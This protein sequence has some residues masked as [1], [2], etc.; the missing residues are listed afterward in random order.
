M[1][2]SR[3][4][5]ERLT[6]VAIAVCG[7][8]A[9]AIGGLTLIG[10]RLQVLRLAAW[11]SELI[12]MSPAAAV[13]S[14]ILGAAILLGVAP[15]S[16]RG[17]VGIRI[18]AAASVLASSFL[19]GL[20]LTGRFASVEHL[21][22]DIH[23]TV[24]NAPLGFIALGSALCFLVV[25]A[26][27][28][29]CSWP[30]EHRVVR[31]WMPLIGGS[32]VM[33]A[34]LGL[35]LINITD[36]AVLY[37][38]AHIPPALNTALSLLL[39]GLALMLIAL[40]AAL[41][42]PVDDARL[43]ASRL[44]LTALFCAFVV[45]I[46]IGG[47]A[48]YQQEVREVERQAQD[49]LQTISQLRLRELANWRE[50]RLW[51][52]AQAAHS[53][54]SLE[55]VRAFLDAA[56]RSDRQRSLTRFFDRYLT[57]VEYD[58]VLL[59]DER[60]R[61]ELSLPATAD[62]RWATG[63]VTRAAQRALAAGK[64]SLYDFY[65]DPT[66]SH[67]S[68]ALFVPV[69]EGPPGPGR[70]LGV[71]CLRI[72]PDLGLYAIVRDWPSSSRS[73]ES[74]LVRR[75]GDAALFLSNLKF[76]AHAAL[77]HRATTTES[78][79]LAF[80]AAQGERGFVRSVNYRGAT[81]L[82]VLAAVPSSPWFLV[83]QIDEAELRADLR[84][85]LVLILAFVVVLVVGAG[86]ALGGIWH[87]QRST[88]HEAQLGLTGALRN[89]EARLRLAVSAADEGL[90]DLDLSTGTAVVTDEY[91]TLFGW[92]PASLATIYERLPE[93]LHPNDMATVSAR[94]RDYL[95]GRIAD[96]RAEFR[97]ADHTGGWRWALSVGRIV[98]RS[99]EGAPLRMLG[100]IKDISERRQA[101]DQ[102]RRSEETLRATATQLRGLL[103]NSPTV[104]YTMRPI[105]GVLR[106]VEVSEN[107]E[108]LFGYSQEEAL[109][110]S[111]WADHIAPEDRVHV[112]S[113]V[114]LIAE[115]DEIAHEFRV[116]RKD[117][118]ISWIQDSLRCTA[119]EHGRPVEVVGA[120]TDITSRKMAELRSKRL[121]ALY[122]TLSECNQAIVRSTRA[123][124]LYAAVCRAAV[125]HGGIAL[126]WI[127]LVDAQGERVVPV[128]AFG[129]STT[130]LDGIEISVDPR[131]A[132][133]RGPT[134]TAVREDRAAWSE[135]F[136]HDPTTA[137][138]HERA[139]GP[140]WSF[141][142]SLPLRRDG[143]AMGALTIYTRDQTV[144][145]EEARALL[146]E[147]S[148]N[149]SYALD[150]FSHEARR[151]DADRALRH[152]VHEKDVL[153]K[154]VHHRVKNNLQLISS[155]LR[156]ETGRTDDLRVHDVLTE[157]QGRILSMALLHETLYRSADLAH[158][159]LG[160]YLTQLARQAFRSL[161]P[162]GHLQLRTTLVDAEVE[163]DQ[164]IPCGL[165]VNELV[166]NAIK[167]GFPDDAPG[168][169]TVSLARDG[170][171]LCLDVRDDGVGLPDDLD[172][173]RATSLGL[174]LV[175]VLA[176]QLNGTLT[177]DSVAGAHFSLRFVPRLSVSE[178]ARTP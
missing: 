155:L 121:T 84:S 95:D 113:A 115:R 32:A 165:L 33:G 162:A 117:G 28:L 73:A 136:P 132:H 88:F 11:R 169:I 86:S 61:V 131:S 25:G 15:P 140:G 101:E 142:G 98:E 164:A 94:L 100:A 40:R 47:W 122:A 43:T 178:P 63:E 17:Q 87:R 13:L 68:L 71:V 103:T 37:E 170:E 21:G 23:G 152:S 176:T 29:I 44:L 174:H 51:D 177:S 62:P 1:P 119:R 7:A 27:L 5:N 89:S 111:W 118:S 175:S 91:A 42:A 34:G 65:L 159:N 78:R 36:G 128:A 161:A 153:L 10:W 125:E 56:S 81:V 39:A 172:A 9:V 60:G 139:R 54:V 69:T 141:S 160:H 79:T 8:A 24:N 92:S 156:L 145:D 151:S 3:V 150:S 30:V 70:A 130:Y 158:I 173:R 16:H 110:P 55:V 41:D 138:W 171:A 102:L 90:W 146:V 75:D 66:E 4:R 127:G 167:H 157:M 120:W 168:T 19:L 52:G 67:P 143:R 96:Y 99:S 72:N 45:S 137:A 49:E 97:V 57:H 144:M 112:F 114:G 106:A 135:D 22:L 46:G 80:R 148:A 76:D 18:L 104:V 20:R 35:A 109:Q 12:P 149:I 154:E 74:L 64:P 134:G 93:R 147:M 107:I 2:R 58:R 133:G 108:R 163:P 123:E 126:A 59:L 116:I 82:G 77:Q 6:V 129:E 166:A 124:D 50:E 85:R 38:G 14:M 105:D 26:S 53:A 31:P 48:F 83:V